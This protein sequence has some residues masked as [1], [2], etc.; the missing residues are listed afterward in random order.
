MDK[1]LKTYKTYKT[2]YGIKFTDC[3]TG[4]RHRYMNIGFETPDQAQRELDKLIR[5]KEKKNYSINDLKNIAPQY[6]MSYMVGIDWKIE[7]IKLRIYS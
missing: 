4:K 7:P 5:E 3:L 6:L 2:Y 1:T